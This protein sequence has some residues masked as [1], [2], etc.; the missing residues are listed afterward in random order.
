MET[1]SL[2]IAIFDQGVEPDVMSVLPEMGIK[3][4][5]K[6]GDVEGSGE[7]G[8]RE[9]TPIWPGLNTVLLIVMPSEQV[10]PLIERLH[11]VRDSFPLTPG[12]KFIIA[13]V[14]MV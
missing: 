13:P 9:G 7:T 1:T 10:D 3:Y 6:F 8:R 4:F 14:R 5:T 12:M 2:V 11:A